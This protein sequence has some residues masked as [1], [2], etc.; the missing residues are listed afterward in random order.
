MVMTVTSNPRLWADWTVPSHWVASP[1][2]QRQR[3]ALTDGELPLGAPPGQALAQPLLC[4]PLVA[5][6][7]HFPE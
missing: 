2:G 6:P 4:A 5:P 1:Q 7:G 3:E